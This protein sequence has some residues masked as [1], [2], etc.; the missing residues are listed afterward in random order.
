MLAYGAREIC[1]LLRGVTCRGQYFARTSE[2]STG[3][4]PV[5]TLARGGVLLS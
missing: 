2:Q 4:V 3:R 5:L 1:A